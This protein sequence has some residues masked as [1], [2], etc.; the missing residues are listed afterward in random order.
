MAR[1]KKPTTIKISW[2]QDLL[3]AGYREFY[4]ATDQ[5]RE[6]AIQFSKLKI[7]QK[8]NRSGWIRK[9]KPV[10][11][12]KNIIFCLFNS[13]IF[14]VFYREWGLQNRA[15]LRWNSEEE[16]FWPGRNVRV[17]RRFRCLQEKV[18]AS[19]LERNITLSVVRWDGVI[20]FYLIQENNNKFW[21][22]RFLPS[23]PNRSAV[24]EKHKRI[25]VRI[26]FLLVC[27]NFLLPTRA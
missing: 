27:A 14:F 18:E 22:R 10:L 3:Q 13:K 23:Q 15:S 26:K 25:S 9:I 20:F 8:K 7:F 4:A 16:Y 5:P 19:D 24:R 6:E 12:T 17:G 11:A 1:R 2:T 21:S